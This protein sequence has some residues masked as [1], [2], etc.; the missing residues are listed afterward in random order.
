MSLRYVMR[1]C[2]RAKCEKIIKAEVKDLFLSGYKAVQSVESKP[3]FR[4]NM[5]PPSSGLKSKPSKK[6]AWSR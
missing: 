5:S 2:V 4:R 6:I 1:I 3:K